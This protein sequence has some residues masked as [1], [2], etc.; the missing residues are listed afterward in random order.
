MTPLWLILLLTA[1]LVPLAVRG[2][3]NLPPGDAVTLIQIR[4]GTLHITRGKVSSLAKEHVLDIMSEAKVTAG[5]IAINA[6]KRVTFSRGI[7][8]TIHQKLR[9]VLLNQ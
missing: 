3:G 7:P 4:A 9:N 1:G 2:L 6:Q 8:G 5:F